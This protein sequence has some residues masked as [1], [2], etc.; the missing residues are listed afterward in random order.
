MSTG[1]EIANTLSRV[2]LA[3]GAPEPDQPTEPPDPKPPTTEPE[4]PP[5]PFSANV[6]VDTNRV[7]SDAKVREVI[8]E[9]LL[10]GAQEPIGT[11]ARIDGKTKLAG[12]F[13]WNPFPKPPE[14]T[15]QPQPTP[16]PTPDPGTVFW[17]GGRG[18]TFE[19]PPEGT[20]TVT[21]DGFDQAQIYNA[22]TG[23]QLY[24]VGKGFDVAA[25]IGSRHGGQ[26]HAINAHANAV[27]DLNAWYS[28]QSDDLTFGTS[29][30][31]WHLA[32][33]NDV[34]LHE[35]G[36]L[37]LDHINKGLSGWYSGEGGAIHEGFGDAIAT[38]MANDPECSEDFPPAMGQPADKGK[39]LRTVDNAL[40]LKNVGRE[41][42][43]RGQVYGGFFWSLKKRLE[44][45][46]G[47]SGRE[48]A[49][50]V[51]KVLVNHAAFYRTTRPKPADFVKAVLAGAEALAQGAS[52]LGVPFEQFRND[53]INEGIARG[54]ITSA[55]EID[56]YT[57]H[58][59]RAFASEADIVA[60]YNN[61]SPRTFFT[62][63]GVSVGRGGTRAEYQQLYRTA[64]NRAARVLGNGFFVLRDTANRVADV[65]ASDIRVLNAGDIIEETRITPTQALRIVQ[66]TTAVELQ[67]A[68]QQRVFF[69][70]RFIRTP[71]DL[72]VLKQAQIAYRMAFAATQQAG[73][74]PAPAAQLVILPGEN[75]LSYE[76]KMGLSLYYVNARTGKVRV[77][78]DVL[79]D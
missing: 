35:A 14:P 5:N 36:H 46:S 68:Q 75:E 51:L 13:R 78:A 10:S 25:M 43:D 2:L 42:H 17:P 50:I 52:G 66:T 1:F 48:S 7:S 38:L 57:L 76:F 47:K 37:L 12:V 11:W 16:T 4:P 70:R 26:H 28:P 60:F 21:N 45:T 71:Q 23:M 9:A 24:L 62:P 3:Y 65:S 6:W 73:R 32:S 55:A 63:V 67:K 27:E 15:P 49:D 69:E 56:G 8:L 72:I 74:M 61:L 31:K 19:A 44:A 53:I 64:D 79:W 54:M 33:D 22:L 30:G 29:N 40:T 41:V 59:R 20:S 39:G 58:A 77:E 18:R 34:S